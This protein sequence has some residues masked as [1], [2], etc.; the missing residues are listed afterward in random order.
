MAAKFTTAGRRL[1]VRMKLSKL[2]WVCG[3][4][5]IPPRAGMG[6]GGEREQNNVNCAAC[7][8]LSIPASFSLI[9]P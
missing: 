6:Q 9:W 8:D 2:R 5:I 4:K 1:A 3:Q 7:S